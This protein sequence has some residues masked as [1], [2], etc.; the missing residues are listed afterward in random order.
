[1]NKKQ[2]I[3]AEI[4]R[5]RRY[6]LA[7][8]GG[9]EEADELVQ[10]CL[11]RALASLDKWRENDNPRSWLFA[12]MHNLFIDGKR[13]ASRR[14][15]EVVLENADKSSLQHNDPSVQAINNIVLKRAL[16]LLSPEHREVVL[17]VGLEGFSY[18]E[19]SKAL[20]IPVGT[21]MSRL[22]RGREKMRELMSEEQGRINT[23]MIRRV[24]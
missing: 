4:P 21:L 12:I 24:K 23:T 17:L 1:M 18:R 2:A 6:A 13:R 16:A 22:S 8:A 19:A 11:E 20:D 10:D 14:P 3:L 7:L 5:L 9:R 15:V